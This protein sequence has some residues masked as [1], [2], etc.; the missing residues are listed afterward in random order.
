MLG[1]GTNLIATRAGMSSNLLGVE[2]FRVSFVE[3]ELGSGS[4]EG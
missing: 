3:P 1:V 4:Y 2:L